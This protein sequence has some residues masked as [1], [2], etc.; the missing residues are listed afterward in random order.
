[1]AAATAA[2][3]TAGPSA[4]SAVT[5]SIADAMISGVDNPVSRYMRE[6]NDP[7]RMDGEN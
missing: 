7:G 5:D 4:G 3:S 2:P 6:I 1:M